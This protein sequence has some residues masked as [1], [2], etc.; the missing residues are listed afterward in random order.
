[1]KLA[2][3]VTGAAFAGVA[4]WAFNDWRHVSDEDRLLTVLNDHCLPYVDTGSTPFGG[5]G[6]ALGVYD[7]ADLDQTLVQGGARLLFDNRFL[8]Q[9]G[10]SPIGDGRPKDVRICRV[11]ASYAAAGAEGF[12][13]P[14]AGLIQKITGAIAP[15]GDL[16][17]D[18]ETVPNGPT[19]IGW[20]EPG[21]DISDGRRVVIVAGGG[22]VAYVVTANDVR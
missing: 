21:T 10:V 19:T 14:D 2:G 18:Y 13:V 20:F 5:M 4:V 6:R 9:W 12:E 17:T 16:V 7:N 15:N 3:F 8:A 1:M 22:W 11:A